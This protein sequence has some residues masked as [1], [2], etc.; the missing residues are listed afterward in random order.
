MKKEI[1][2]MPAIAGDMI[3]SPYER[4]GSRIKTT[5]FPLFNEKSHPT[6]DS[7]MTIAVANALTSVYKGCDTPDEVIMEAVTKAMQDMG[8]RYPDAG[9][10]GSFQKWLDDPKPYGSWGNGSA[11]R[12]SPV[13]YVTYSPSEVLRLARLTAEVSHNDP[14]G[15]KGAQAVAIA[16]LY[17]RKG[18]SKSTIKSAIENL[19]GYDLNRTVDEIRPGYG[20]DVSCPGSVPEA[21]IA[22]LDSSSYVDAVRKAVSLGGDADTQACIAGAI[23]GA[24]YGMPLLVK[25]RAFLRLDWYCRRAVLKAARMEAQK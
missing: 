19:F 9:Y 17:A 21:I 1:R 15:V 5:Q 25:L 22:F 4:K 8:H 10:G 6:D 18:C 13:A 23:A 24:Y 12:V 14:E 7:M 16:V 20:F 11:M 3:G 2:I